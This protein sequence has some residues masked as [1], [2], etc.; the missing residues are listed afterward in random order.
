[1]GNNKLNEN[2]N[3]LVKVDQ[4]NLFF[5]DPNSVVND[6][7][8]EPR[9]LKQENLVMYVNLEADII[10]RSI[11]SAS[12][13]QTSKGEV[14]SIAKGTL[15]ILKNQG[16]GDFDS[17]WTNAYNGKDETIFDAN[18]K[19]TGNLSVNNVNFDGTAQSFGIDSIN[20][21]IKGANFIPQ[22]NI[23]FIDVRGKTLFESPENSPYKAFFHLPWPIFYLTVKGFYG[24]AIRYRLHLTKFTSKFNEGNGNFEI[25]TTFVGSTYAFLNDIP[26]NGILNAPYM[27]AIEQDVPTTLNPLTGVQE[28]KISKTSKGYTMLRSVYSEYKE[29]GLIDKDF[30]VRTLKELIVI[31]K[32]LD[33]VLEKEIFSGVVDFKVFAGLKEFE[34]LIQD[35]ENAVRLW[36]GSNLNPQPITVNGVAYNPLAG[37][38]KDTLDNVIGTKDTKTL[39]NLLN[40]YPEHLTKS[41]LFVENFKNQG[42]VDF[43]KETFNYINTIKDVNKYVSKI[44]GGIYAV[45][46]QSLLKDIFDIQRTFV[47]QRDKLEQTVEARMNDI[48]KDKNKGIGFEPTIRNIFAVVMANADVYIRLLKDVHQRSF[49]AGTQRKKL[50]KGFSDETPKEDSIYPWPEIKKVTSDAKQKVLAYPGD[51][52]LQSKLQSYD[53]TLWPE[54]DFVENYQAISTKKIDTNSSKEG[55]VGNVNFIFE[56]NS[57]EVKTNK[58]STLFEAG[59]N[60]PYSNKSVSSVLYEI[61]ERARYTTLFDAFNNGAVEE[62]ANVEIKNLQNLLTEDFDVIGVL[63]SITDRNKLQDYLLSFS[64]FERYPYYQDRIATVPYIKDLTTNSF[65][66][67]SYFGLTENA[68]NDGLYTKLSDNLINYTSEEYRTNI[69]PFNSDLYLSYL[70]KSNFDKSDLELKGILNVKTT[71]GLVSSPI[72]PLFWVKDGNTNNLFNQDFRLLNSS[73][74]ILNTPYF[75]K[76]LFNDF[77]KTLPHGKYVGSSYLLLNSLPFHDLEDNVSFGLNTTRLSTIFREVG[78]SHYVPYHLMLKWGSLYHRYK[79]KIL[80]NR[81][82]L[83]GFLNVSGTTQPINREV[84]FDITTGTTFD[85]TADTTSGRVTYNVDLSDKKDIGIHPFYDGIFHQIVNGYSH[86]YISAGNSSYSGNTDNSIINSRVKELKDGFRYWTNYVDNSIETNG[87]DK[88]FTLLP[89]DGGNKVDNLD[90]KPPIPTFPIVTFTNNTFESKEQNNF[91]IIWKD[92]VSNVDYSGRTFPSAYEYNRTFVTGDTRNQFDNL[93]GITDNFRKV[94]DLIATFSP[95]ILDEFENCFLDFASEKLNEEVSYKKFPTINDEK[96]NPH[97]VRYD[98][99]QDLLKSI[100]TI[101]KDSNDV[102]KTI[103]STINSIKTKQN[104]KLSTITGDMLHSDNLI[105]VTIANPKEID[106]YVWYGFVN[107]VNSFSYNNYDASQDANNLKYIKLYVGEDVD[108]KYKQFFVTNNVELSEDNVLQ[109]RPLILIFAG[110]LKSGGVNG[111]TEFQNYVANNILINAENRFSIFINRLIPQ[112]Q[113]LKIKDTANQVTIVNGYNDTPLK[114]ELYNFFKSFNDKWVGGNSIGQRLLLEEFLFLDKANKD[115]GSKAFLSLE[116]LL[117]LDDTKNNKQ[118]LYG[119]I[120][121]LLQGSGFDMRGLPAYVNFYGTNTSNKVKLTPSKKLAQNLFGTFLDV[122]Y[123][124]SSPKIIVQYTGPTSKHLEMSDIDEKYKFKND[125]GNLFS[126]PNSP[127]VITVPEVFKTGDLAKSNKVVAFEVS[128]GDQNQSMFKGV[129][130]DQTSIKNTTES[131]GVMENLGRSESGNGAQQIDIGLFD[132][133]RQSSYTCEVTMMGN[134]MIQPTMYFYLKNIPMFRGSYWITE[135]SHNIKSG[136]ITTTFK[137]TRIPYASLPDPKDSFL[138]S[139]RAL[140]DRITKSA[141]ARVQEESLRISGATKNEITITTN[142]GIF[143]VDMGGSDKKIKG[144]E[145]TSDSGVSNFGVQYN[146]FNGEK[147]V[148]KVNYKGKEVFRAIATTMGGKDNP[149]EDFIDMTILCRASATSARVT[150]DFMKDLSKTNRFYSTKFR[151]ASVSADKIITGTTTFINPNNGDKEVTVPPVHILSGNIKVEGAVSAGP[152]VN[153]FGISMSQKLMTDLG[154]YN[155]QVVYFT[156]K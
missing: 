152:S 151:L 61:W 126:G 79:T 21:N 139:Y 36:G 93:Y 6:G 156:I 19:A 86:Y 74:N 27:F 16:G 116:K 110:Y 148:Q 101:D 45:A 12:G 7:V 24:K 103:E 82:I 14:V 119:V 100:V 122:D 120:A 15:N 44:E 147:Y 143:T 92:E 136:N 68:N 109:F 94:T 134:V 117:P 153:G 11:L 56:N 60:F 1:M 43:K 53:K 63:Q 108:G 83:D 77:N 146:G 71:E 141:L 64:P 59:I 154:L 115:I 114:L 52:D 58:I 35:F 55:G 28:K 50:L 72:N 132:I 34:K 30:P 25:T 138:S 75:H 67:E 102:G 112:L 84:F 90:F 37:P 57:Q 127:L 130:L 39:E 107:V 33:K 129:Q 131:F 38:K 142:E 18:G 88:Y 65:N 4:N 62:L 23:N 118:N 3:I 20:I 150:W 98:K 69:Y 135:V 46:F 85:A 22:I 54:V 137:G 125:S 145:I 155:G 9:G 41:K 47:A 51:P 31:S 96:G 121:M 40:I 91:R 80:E 97:Y 17:S 133:Y 66:V 73:A 5:I 81:D 104:I 128:V 78:S 89:C 124:E 29:K 10:P 87:K 140:F 111:K 42:G 8:I 49:D 105:K 32:S 106:S 99:F 113:T 123:Q 144:E 70:N 76:Q 149:L 48:I 13:D 26:L 95:A 2:E